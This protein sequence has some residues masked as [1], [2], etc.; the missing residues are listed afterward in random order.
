MIVIIGLGTAGVYATR[1]ITTLNRDEEITIVE[2]HK[3]ESYSPCG[4][5]FILEKRDDFSKLKHP[6]PRTK[7]INVLLEHEA[8]SIDTANKT[9]KLL[10]KKNNEIMEIKYDKLFFAAGAEPLIPKIKNVQEFLNRGLFVVKTLEDADAIKEHITK[11]N[12]KDASVIG[13]GA[14]GLEV[15]HSLKSLGL[16]VHVFEMFPQP[17]PRVL[18][19]E[20]AEIVKNEVEKTGIKVHL[21][22][23][24][25][26]IVGENGNLKGVKSADSVI[27]SQVVILATGVYPNTKI[28]EGKVNMERGFIL[29]NE[30]MQTSDPDIY[31]A[32]D[33]ILV[34]NFLDVS[35]MPVQLATTAAKQGIV[36]GINMAGF[37]AV[38]T[39]AL[40]TFASAFGEFEIAAVGMTETQAKEKFEVITSRAKA[41]DRPEYAGGEEITLKLVIDKKSGSIIG[42]QAFGRNASSKINVLSLAIRKRATIFDLSALEMAYCPKV[43]DLYDVINMA[44]DLALRK[45]SPKS[46]MF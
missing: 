19:P 6:F 43:S 15:A 36:A 2:R 21:S 34:R 40:G 37:E 27:E 44:A 31:A 39:G 28:L 29:V 41:L 16:N 14:I 46:Y 11:N 13:A 26:E 45:L 10:N 33:C 32:G 42:A 20:M 5:P 24:V 30:R 7:R 17:F 1:W 4:I 22:S 18:D 38:Y 12:V 9:V 35:L 8:T 23:R 3:Y 25:D